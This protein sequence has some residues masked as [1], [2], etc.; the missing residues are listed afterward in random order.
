MLYQPNTLLLNRDGYFADL[1][2]CFS[3]F[4][5]V[6]ASFDV[7][8]VLGPFLCRWPEI[9]STYD[10]PHNYGL[11]VKKR[12]I[13]VT[14]DSFILFKNPLLWP[15]FRSIFLPA[16]ITHSVGTCSSTDW[17]FL[18]SS[19]FLL[20]YSGSCCTPA[21]SI[22]W[23]EWLASKVLLDPLLVCSGMPLCRLVACLLTSAFHTVSSF[24]L[25]QLWHSCALLRLVVFVG[26]VDAG[27]TSVQSWFHSML[28][29]SAVDRTAGLLF[30]IFGGTPSQSISRIVAPVSTGC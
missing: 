11:Q 2:G 29:P 5:G 17:P 10:I 26:I 3:L 23:T 7:R 15:S 19:V 21:S 27:D 28:R 22:A 24:W 25:L 20:I 18:R 16:A 6:A 4:E 1:L 12:F 8:H 9:M 13:D 14:I 30:R